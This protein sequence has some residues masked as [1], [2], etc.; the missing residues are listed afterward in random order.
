MYV[1][2]TAAEALQCSCALQPEREWVGLR[3]GRRSVRLE[4]E[5][6]SIGGERAAAGTLRVVHNYGESTGPFL[7][8]LSCI[9]SPAA[10]LATDCEDICRLMGMSVLREVLKAVSP[11]QGMEEEA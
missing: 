10:G 1:N 3:P 5:E 9:K 2:Q 6:A 8:A 4:Y 11:V 7:M